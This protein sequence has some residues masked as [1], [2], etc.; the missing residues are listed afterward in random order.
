MDSTSQD[1]LANTATI[2]GLF[3]YIM[4]FQAEITIL[5]L[6]TSLALNITR[7]YNV[8]KKKK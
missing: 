1:T 4:H 2:T 8:F 3:A 5:V 7:L 6:L